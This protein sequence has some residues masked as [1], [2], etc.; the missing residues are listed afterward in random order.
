VTR[1]EGIRRRELIAAGAAAAGAFAFGP[2]FWRRAFEA[3]A[4]TA[5][6]G[7]YGPLL[8]PDANGIML[9]AGFSSREIA[10]ANQPV[11]G[12]SY[13]WHIFPDGQATYETGD[14]GW[15]L[16]SNSESLAPR[17]GGASAI[18]FAADG[19]IEDA[20][21]ILSD[22]QTNCAGGRTPWG[23]WLS[24]EE[25]DGGQV[26]EA[27]PTG[28]RP[29]AVRPA[30]GVFNHEAVAVDPVGRRLYL[31]EDKPDGGFYRFTPTAY[32][33]L[34]TGL[35]E[36]AVVNGASVSWVAVPDPSAISVPTRQQLPEMTKF[37]GGEGIWFDSG[38]VY[39]STKGDNRIRAYDTA[40][41]TLE[42]IYDAD[43]TPDA[44]LRGVDNVTVS[45]FGDVYVCEDG[46]NLEVCMITPEREV[47]PVL[48]VTG[49]QH[50]G[51]QFLG[52]ASELAGVIFDP[53]G[54]RLY[55][56]SQRGF[57]AGVVYEVSGPFRTVAARTGAP[58]AGGAILDQDPPGVR[59]TARRRLGYRRIIARGGL[60][61][62]V[63]VDEPGQVAISLTTADAGTRPGKRGSSPRPEPLT[64]GR[65]RRRFRRAGTRKL[66]VKVR[67]RKL[68]KLRRVRGGRSAV[69]R[70]I[71]QVRDE[72]GNV[73]VASR[74]VRLDLRGRR[75]G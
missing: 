17:G 39:F 28:E 60:P 55:V 18:R 53:S 14:G 21:R 9:P 48:R 75:A 32:P 49:P 54:R 56:S 15:I 1:E 52:V 71:V 67:R 27:D 4:A 6:T 70:V 33:D 65:M 19:S 62:R 16:V 69:A 72:A 23:T 13:L 38:T 61:V 59:V 25:Y 29:A 63:K 66:I 10:R 31:T 46:D 47:A 24:C 51:A 74:R 30:L 43:A 40:A 73:S 36:L 45:S 3:S 35:L 58:Q 2:T 26:W 42:V 64:L 34:T 50:E 5:G 22:T 37:S 68:R 44:P 8:P 41:S 20:Y 12:T 7:P 11:Q 57:G